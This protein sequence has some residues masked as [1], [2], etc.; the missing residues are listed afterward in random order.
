MGLLLGGR[1]SSND[2]NYSQALEDGCSVAALSDKT[3]CERNNFVVTSSDYCN[4]EQEYLKYNQEFL[5]AL[6]SSVERKKVNVQYI[7]SILH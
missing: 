4:R 5:L 2:I 7:I 3:P 1:I 6:S